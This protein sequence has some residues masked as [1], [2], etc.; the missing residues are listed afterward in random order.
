M[1][2]ALNMKKRIY[3]RRFRPD[4]CTAEFGSDFYLEVKA[5]GELADMVTP[6]WREQRHW[7]TEEWLEK[8]RTEIF[9]HT[10]SQLDGTGVFH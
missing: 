8:N 4:D 9:Y 6:H 1:G 3:P 5:P 10:V 7:M 2:A